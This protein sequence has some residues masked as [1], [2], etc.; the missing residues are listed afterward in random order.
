MGLIYQKMGRQ[1]LEAIPNV[2]PRLA[3]LVMDHIASAA[4][5]PSS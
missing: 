3:A 4:A 1:G 5:P 2:S